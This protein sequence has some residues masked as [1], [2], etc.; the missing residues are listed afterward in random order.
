[1]HSGAGSI[2]GPVWQVPILRGYAD[3]VVIERT[4]DLESPWFVAGHIHIEGHGVSL[5][6][7]ILDANLDGARRCPFSFPDLSLLERRRE[8]RRAGIEISDGSLD[9]TLE[10]CLRLFLLLTPDVTAHAAPLD[11]RGATAERR[12]LQLSVCVELNQLHALVLDLALEL[13]FRALLPRVLAQRTLVLLDARSDGR[14]EG[15]GAG[16]LRSKVW[17][18]PY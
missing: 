2:S 11:G 17:K 7:E 1:M 6:H 16:R 9:H 13:Q 8:A 15:G 12:S 5:D 4:G 3:R 14:S 10:V 18:N